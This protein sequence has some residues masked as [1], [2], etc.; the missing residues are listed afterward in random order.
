MLASRGVCTVHGDD[1]F[2]PTP[3]ANALRADAPTSVRGIVL[4]FGHPYH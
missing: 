4:F 2:G 1:R 3:M